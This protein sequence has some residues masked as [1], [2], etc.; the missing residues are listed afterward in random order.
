MTST[1]L[2]FML[3][4][5]GGRQST[6]RTPRGRVPPPAGSWLWLRWQGWTEPDDAWKSG[7]R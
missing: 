3:C 1:P 6:V 4:A 7:A 2:V 5:L